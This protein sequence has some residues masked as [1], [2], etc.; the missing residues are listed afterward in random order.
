MPRTSSRGAGVR[1]QRVGQRL[2]AAAVARVRRRCSRR[3]PR[4][5]WP[6]DH[7]RSWR[8]RAW[9]RPAAAASAALSAQRHQPPRA[10][11]LLVRIRAPLGGAVERQLRLQH[12]AGRDARDLG[13]GQVEVEP[14]SNATSPSS[15]RTRSA[16][17]S[18][19]MATMPVSP[20]RR[21]TAAARART[22]P[23]T[24]GSSVLVITQP[25]VP[26]DGRLQL[27]RGAEQIVV[28]EVIERATGERVH[29]REGGG[30]PSAPA[31]GDRASR[32]ASASRSDEARVRRGLGVAAR[33]ASA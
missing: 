1:E 3:A 4:A 30:R 29:R 8:T 22:P 24:S 26:V 6:A 31:T 20:S 25:N 15:P 19:T 27:A 7:R 33:P 32:S 28:Q 9:P 12:V 5:G 11:E 17:R 13:A 21:A 18:E 14:T 10:L 16:L 2:G 23:T